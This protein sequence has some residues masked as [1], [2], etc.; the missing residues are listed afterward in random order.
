MLIAAG[1]ILCVGIGWLALSFFFPSLLPFSF[2]DRQ[3]T[4]ERVLP[5]PRTSPSFFRTEKTVSL[6]ARRTEQT[7]FLEK[8]RALASAPAEEAKITALAITIEG[9][10][11]ERFATLDD[12][13]TLSRIQ[14]P[15]EFLSRIED[16]PVFFLGGVGDSARFGFAVK[17]RDPDRTLADMIKWEP[18]LPGDFSPLFFGKT[19]PLVFPPF[20]NETTDNVDWRSLTLSAERRLGIYYALFPAGNIL[21]VTTDKPLMENIITRLLHK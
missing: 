3:E 14:A 6:G 21:V 13:F 15:A 8:I 1:I 17:T 2:F 18:S 4:G 20:E 12:F 19:P 16:A 10:R 7:A 9:E 5:R 11:E